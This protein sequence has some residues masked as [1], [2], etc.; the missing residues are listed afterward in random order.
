MN[1]KLLRSFSFILFVFVAIPL[2]SQE[3]LQEEA[4]LF[5]SNTKIESASK[6]TQ[7]INEVP[8]TVTIV[9]SDTIEKMGFRTVAEVLNFYSTSMATFYD[10]RYEFGITRGFYEFEDYNTRVLVLV[11][12]VIINEPTNNFAGLERSLPIPLELV[13]RIEITYGPFG[14]LYGTSN[15]G[16]IINIVTKKPSSLPKFFAKVSAGSFR[17]KELMGGFRF[18]T[19]FKELPLEGYFSATSYDTDGA[20]SGTERILLSP[21]DNWYEPL[22]W[23]F[24]SLYGGKWNKRCDFE[25]AP[26]LFGKLSFG[27]FSLTAFWGYRKKGEPYAPWGDVYGDNNNWVKDER[28]QISASFVHSFSD[29][30]S[31]SS[32]AAYDDYSYF[33]NDTYADTKFFPNSIGYFWNDSMKARRASAE[34][35]A[36]WN[37]A[38]SKY[39]F[40]A[41]YKREKLYDVVS[42]ESIPQG[43][44]FLERA[45]SLSQRAYAIYSMGEWKISKTIL[46]IAGNYVKYNY[47]NGEFLYRGS[48]IYPFS[49]KVLL[50]IVAGKGFRVPSYYEYEYSDSISTLN[51]PAL[52][53]ETSPS[54]EMALTF[55]PSLTQSYTFS[56]FKQDVSDMITPVTIKD[57]SQIEGNV[58][59]A[60]SN[61]NDF[62]GFLQYQNVD[63]VHIKGAS[64][65]GKWFMTEGI[66]I[67]SS[68]S[69]Q[70][71][72]KE[73]QSSLKI[74][75][76][77]SPRWTGNAGAIYESEK[78]FASLAFSYIGSF[79]TSE[80]HPFPP[81]KITSSWSGRF[82]FGVKNFFS[83]KMKLT[84]TVINPFDFKGRVPLSPVFVPSEGRRSN[85]SAVLSLVYDF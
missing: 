36:L 37:L 50:K 80:G 65:S 12:G 5:F 47:T 83:P 19:T 39:I 21:S 76:S 41:Y 71:S 62:I 6:Y 40:G 70:D 72:K 49:E 53:S 84:L 32:K 22:N 82:H 68:L 67:Y 63:K 73:T 17:E 35:S 30:F 25:R 29:S 2:F 8:A 54:I 57:P 20:I 15:L 56:L 66:S 60:G 51:N 14:V 45:D 34:V 28:A 61:P 16:G 33:E 9:T 31:I 1:Q 79:L 27:D 26:S 24:N 74:R 55:N 23:N 42:E 43:K 81:Y 7:S 85:R 48:F 44:S 38:K 52:K 58:I 59:P 64:F 69:Y 78:I 3:S 77:G 4:N 46:S 75:Q 11:D 10:R 13:E 18:S